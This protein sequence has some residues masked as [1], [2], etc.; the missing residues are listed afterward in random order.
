VGDRISLSTRDLTLQ[1]KNREIKKLI[2]KL[3]RPYKI[4]KFILENVV[5]LELLA[6]MK[7]HL[8][9]NVSRITIYQ[10]QVEGKK[11]ILS[12]PVEIDGEKEY[13][14]EKI[15]NRRDIRGK[16]KYFVRWKRN[17]VEKDTWK[18]LENLGN[19]MELVKKF[20]KKI[21]KK[22]IKQVERRKEKRKKKALDLEAEVFKR[23]ELLEKYI[24]KILFE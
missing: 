10:E 1:I 23:S 17:I 9:V 18:G 6:S 2:E 4:K 16:P 20:E 19:M 15:L 13:K 24:V 12:L 11:K 3:I 7:I 8:M 14:V 21:R 5:E 22:E